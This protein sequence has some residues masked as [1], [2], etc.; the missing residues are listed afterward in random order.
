MQSFYGVPVFSGTC[1]SSSHL[2]ALDTPPLNA[3]SLYAGLEQNR[4][5]LIRSASFETATRIFG[6]L[7]DHYGLRSSYN[8][9]MQYVVHLTQ[10]RDSVGDVA[11]TVNRR[12]PFQ[13]IPPHAEGDTTSQLDLF[14]IHCVRNAVAGGENVF[15]LINQKAD[16]SKIRAKEKAIVGHN[17]STSELEELRRHHRN[18]KDVLA[19]SPPGCRTL[20]QGRRGKVVVRSLPIAA[21]RSSITNDRLVTFW[22]NVTIHDHAFHRH[23]FELLRGLALVHEGAGPGY[24]AYM[25]VEPDSPWTPVDTDSGAVEQTAKLFVSHIVYKMQAGD[26]VVFNNRAW[27]HAA[28][29]WPPGEFRE[30]TAMYA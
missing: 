4:L 14:G 25:Y 16:F 3:S 9:Q 17:L 19:S 2:L 7:V 15:S 22:D 27:T 8:L 30:L 26:F 10:D 6:Q 29:N 21:Y 20:L 18:A 24:K 12:A 13:I 1:A 5:V 28:N 11:V 23:H